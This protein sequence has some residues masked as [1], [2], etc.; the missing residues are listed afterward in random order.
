MKPRAL[1]TGASGFIG[2]R[3]VCA[4]RAEGWHV[5][6]LARAGSDMSRV[7]AAATVH[8]ADGVTTEEL[9][10]IVGLAEPTVVFHLA[11]CFV[12]EHKPHQVG[13]LMQSNVEFGAHL[14]EA[15]AAHGRRLLVNT[16]TAWQHFHTEGYSPVC[17]Y[18]ATKQAFEA[19]AQFYVEVH[20]L[21]CIT[22][23]L[24]DSYGPGDP[25]KKLMALLQQVAETGQPIDFSAGE[26]MVD[27][28]HIDDVVRAFLMAA[29]RLR[30]GEASG[31][32][33]YALTTDAMVPLKELIAQFEA[34]CGR[35]LAIRLGAR[36]YRAREVMLP[37]SAGDRLPGWT[38]R[39]PLADG[40]R[41]MVQA[42]AG[43][44]QTS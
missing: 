28:L 13:E 11:S 41:Q 12:A 25:R 9:T 35:P 30:R 34:A 24:S 19:I 32:E 6:V 4:L 17:L 29:D 10:R 26:Q 27:L 2:S 16:G 37:W 1:V 40:L 18:A 5:E 14:L 36:P 22:L 15:M 42:G 21:R 23:K 8:V 3:L 43:E 38:A 33:R 20:G 39:V 31:H 44:R 7:S